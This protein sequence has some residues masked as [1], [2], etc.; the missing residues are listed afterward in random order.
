MNW[1]YYRTILRENRWYFLIYAL[2][3]VAGTVLLLF[4][5]KGDMIFF[6]SDHRSYWGD[7]SFRFITTL[8]EEMV[9]LIALVGLLFYRYR[10][11]IILPVVGLSVSL[12]SFLTKK[13]FHHDRPSLYFRKQELIDTIQLVDGVYLNGG[14]NSF[15]SGHTMSAF[16]FYTFIALVIPNKKLVAAGLIILAILV[17][18]SR[19]YLVQH[20]WQ[21]VY[22]GSIIGVGLGT[23]WY[24]LISNKPKQPHRWM[25]K[26]LLSRKKAAA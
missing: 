5:E 3:L 24:V 22:L 8:G 19:V 7:L 18:V 4:I 17:G 14:S 13:F 11:A 9:Y 20:F 2:F 10:Y 12:V 6:F 21:D 15:P 23:F 16:A 1:K 25:D 26:S